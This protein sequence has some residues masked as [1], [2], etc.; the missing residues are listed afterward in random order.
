M[1]NFKLYYKKGEQLLPIT[2]FDTVVKS[3]N[4]PT[5][6]YDEHIEI[7]EN[8][9]TTL[10]FSISKYYWEGGDASSGMAR[11]TTK[12]LNPWYNKLQIHSQIRLVIDDIQVFDLVIKEISPNVENI[13]PTVTYT[14]QDYFSY[15]LTRRQQGFSYCNVLDSEF[16]FDVYPELYDGY[17]VEDIFTIAKKILRKAH[18]YEWQVVYNTR[19][20]ES[21][22]Q[23]KISLNVENSNPYNAIVEAC[24][25]LNAYLQVNYINKTIGFVEKNTLPFS[26]YRYTP[27]HNLRAIDAT[28]NGEEL[29]TL[30]RIQGGTDENDEYV[31]IAPTFPSA[32]SKWLSWFAQSNQAVMWDGKVIESECSGWNNNPDN[33]YFTPQWW[34]NI[35]TYIN[36]SDKVQYFY[37]GYAPWQESKTG[38]TEMAFKIDDWNFSGSGSIDDQNK[39]ILTVY[40]IEV[41]KL[42]P[43]LAIEEITAIEDL[44]K[45]SIINSPGPAMKVWGEIEK[46]ANGYP[47]HDEAWGLNYLQRGGKYYLTFGHVFITR[48]EPLEPFNNIINE[49]FKGWCEN[50]NIVLNFGDT[51]KITEIGKSYTLYRLSQNFSMSPLKLITPSQF[52]EEDEQILKEEYE[53]ERQEI[54]TFFTLIERIPY[55]GQFLIDLDF[56]RNSGFMSET[57][58]TN[59]DILMRNMTR[60]NI[61]SRNLTETKLNLEFTVRSLLQEL[62]GYGDQYAGTMQQYWDIITEEEA[63]AKEQAREVKEEDIAS[64]QESLL[65]QFILIEHNADSVLPKLVSA[66]QKLNG[67]KIQVTKYPEIIEIYNKFVNA[68]SQY[69]KLSAKLANLRRLI[70]IQN[71]SNLESTMKQAEIEDLESRL[72]TWNTLREKPF[73]DI[74]C[75]TET[76]TGYLPGYGAYAYVYHK[77]AEYIYMPPYN[78]YGLPIAEAYNQCQRNLQALESQLYIYFG[79]YIVESV[80]SNED[81]LDPV[82]LYNQAI[83][84]FEDINKPKA[85][86]GIQ[87]LSTAQLEKIFLPIERIGSKIR[88]YNE[89][90]QLADGSTDPF[91][92]RN[93]ELMITSISYDLRDPE[94]KE[95][96]VEKITMY[97]SIVQKLI[98]TVKRK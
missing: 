2:F 30:L 66:L 96:G 43:N 78:A 97:D 18:L 44:P 11:N 35:H 89:E 74:N 53:L 40:Q 67:N 3:T 34:N 59:F 26:G 42:F 33:T 32:V 14:A 84:Y 50:N 22:G 45:V 65:A 83:Q 16:S 48:T 24:N 12:L 87:V 60:W 17:G 71:S 8:D 58:R 52:T 38:Y 72:E 69:R 95:F 27:S 54:D 20:D 15:I 57:Q 46:D 47:I 5:A 61:L 88:I 90:L 75:A 55:C 37:D 10:T 73:K 39:Y 1:K 25:I 98:Q 93:N 19:L 91:S 79:D 6:T 94:V 68:E 49:D 92:Q 51:P 28:Y 77:I 21:L 81:E 76:F 62:Y 13:N 63:L 70:G 4:C 41:E 82:S 80:Y 64:R 86:Y 31:Y 85:T 23:K 9:Q 29:T 56:F 36:E 7:A